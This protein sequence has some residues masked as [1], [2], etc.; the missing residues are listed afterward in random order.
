MSN[1]NKPLTSQGASGMIRNYYQAHRSILP[2]NIDGRM[3]YAALDYTDLTLPFGCRCFEPLEYLQK[4]SYGTNSIN[5]KA[6]FGS[7]RNSTSLHPACRSASKVLTAAGSTR[8]R[9]YC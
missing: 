3:I 2:S 5:S 9:G 1:D 7:L 8:R 6:T 4:G